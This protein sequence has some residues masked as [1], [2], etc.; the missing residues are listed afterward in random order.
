MFFGVMLMRFTA[1]FFWVLW[2]L[3]MFSCMGL[4]RISHAMTENPNSW[5]GRLG[6]AVVD[7]MEKSST[8]GFVGVTAGVTIVVM[9]VTFWLFKKQRVTA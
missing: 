6:W 9:A 8:A 5:V 1:K 4:P 7:F 2:A 3:W